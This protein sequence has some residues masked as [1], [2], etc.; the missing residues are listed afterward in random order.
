[1]AGH[2][3]ILMLVNF[4]CLSSQEAAASWL[5][6]CYKTVEEVHSTVGAWIWR[7]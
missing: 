6:D 7:V 2:E 5:T 3:Q 4:P 1:M